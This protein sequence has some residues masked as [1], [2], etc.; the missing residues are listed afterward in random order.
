[1][2]RTYAFAGCTMT[3]LVSGEQTGGAF[4]ALHVIKPNGSS[5]PPHSHDNETELSYVLSGT[6]GVETEGAT[7]S[8]GAGGCVV[9]PPVRPHRL[10][11][12]SGAAV[13]EFLLCSPGRFEEFVT[14]AGEPVAPFAEPRSMTDE[15]RGRLISLAPDFGLQLLRTAAPPDHPP[16]SPASFG[17][18]LD[19]L[20]AGIELLACLG[21][22]DDD[23]ALLRQSLE[24]GQAVAQQSHNGHKA[25]FGISGVVDIYRDG[26]NGG[27]S[28]LKAEAAIHI[29]PSVSH[30]IRNSGTARAEFLVVTPLWTARHLAAP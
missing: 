9:L 28:K 25:I 2:T 15:E 3:V 10:F 5:T 11:N 13:R 1:M 26:D 7:T 17:R 6:L 30:A 24:P 8:Y 16:V 21:D 12:E 23:L 27:W 14:A 20:S 22:N 4:A 29:A 19:V 18:H